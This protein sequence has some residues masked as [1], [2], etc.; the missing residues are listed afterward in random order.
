MSNLNQDPAS[1][2][3]EMN[4]LYQKGI[5]CFNSHDYFTAHDFFEELWME[6]RDDNK[7]FLHGMIQISVGCFHLISGNTKGALSLL[8]KGIAKIVHFSPVFAGVNL[9]PLVS[10]LKILIFHIENSNLNIEQLLKSL[11][12]IKLTIKENPSWQL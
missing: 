5:R 3:L 7:K 1:E 2:N 8:N 9:N 4:E 12:E 10:D 6:E 11:P